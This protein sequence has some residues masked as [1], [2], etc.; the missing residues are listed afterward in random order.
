MARIW[1]TESTDFLSGGDEDDLI[2]GFGGDDFLSG[3]GGDDTLHGGDGNDQLNGEAGDDLLIG[4]AGDD[5]FGWIAGQG[6]DTMLGGEGNDI[7][8]I[9]AFAAFDDVVV[10]G[11]DGSDGLF[12]RG[13]SASI[14]L[15]AGTLT[16]AAGT[17]Q[18]LGME[19]VFSQSSQAMQI[20][21]NAA[22]N[23]LEGGSGVDTINGRAGNDTLWGATGNDVY[24][25][26]ALGEADA[27]L[28]F[29]EKYDMERF[30]FVENDRIAL[31]SGVMTELGATGDFSADDDRFYAAA[32]ATGGEDAEDRIIHDTDSGR[33]YY[34]AD[35]SGDGE[36]Q[37][38]ATV[39]PFG[40]PLAAGDITVI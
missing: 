37:L 12:Y 19:N 25:L 11:G 10:S 6:S 3:G 9:D 24:V 26:G 22:N 20:S 29:F 36:A 31:D 5:N 7:F 33:L 18:L 16:S 34:D 32:G 30:G 27:D 40:N 15:E 14:D 1:G 28:V 17:M 23:W 2:F 21:G 39:V 8:F 4:A 13:A 38:I 35:G